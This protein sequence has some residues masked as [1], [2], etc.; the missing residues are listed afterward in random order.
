MPSRGFN[1]QTTKRTQFL[2]R[3]KVQV[4]YSSIYD[5][6]SR[7]LELLGCSMNGNSAAVGIGGRTDILYHLFRQQR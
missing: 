7:S 6:I 1:S 4:N 2:H 5:Q 3:R